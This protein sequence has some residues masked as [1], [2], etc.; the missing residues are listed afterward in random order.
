M[1]GDHGAKLSMTSTTSASEIQGSGS[2][3]TY[4]GWWA[5]IAVATAQY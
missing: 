2:C 1:S 4:I 5:E 3:P